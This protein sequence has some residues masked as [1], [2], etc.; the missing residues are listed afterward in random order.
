MTETLDRLKEIQTRHR[1]W[2]RRL[3]IWLSAVVCSAGF[4]LWGMKVPL[5]DELKALVGLILMLLAAV[6]YKI[7]HI[8]FL[9]NRRYYATDAETLQLMGETWDLYKKRM[10]L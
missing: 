5:T 3:T 1:N 9:L 7:P 10:L 4:V 6:F 8:A 2:T